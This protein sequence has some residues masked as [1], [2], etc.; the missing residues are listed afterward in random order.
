MSPTQRTLKELKRQGWPLVEITER[1]NPWSKTRHD[2]FNFCDVLA[3]RQ[4]E[5]LAIQC[6]SGTNVSARL[7]KI[8]DN[9]AHLI[10]LASPSRRLEVW[11]WRKVGP[12]G[13]RKMWEVRIEPLTV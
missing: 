2:L 1:W 11:G 12:R 4:D 7:T 5:I 6:T 13:K 9:P 8:R 3:C 10:W